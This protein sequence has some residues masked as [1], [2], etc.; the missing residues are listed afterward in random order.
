MQNLYSN[1]FHKIRALKT[2]NK[3]DFLKIINLYYSEE[4]Q[5]YQVFIPGLNSNGFNKESLSKAILANKQDDIQIR[6]LFAWKDESLATGLQYF[7]A[8]LNE[9]KL[10]PKN[11][12]HCTA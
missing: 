11:D 10:R 9:K 7:E 2:V 4:K 5:R 6:K 8:D 12:Y 3:R 1:F